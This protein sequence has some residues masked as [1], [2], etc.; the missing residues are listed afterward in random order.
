MAAA[1]VQKRHALRCDNDA[2]QRCYW[3]AGVVYMTT[4]TLPIT[5]SAANATYKYDKELNGGTTAMYLVAAVCMRAHLPSV[6]IQVVDRIFPTLHR[7]CPGAGCTWQEGATSAAS[8]CSAS[9][10]LHMY[11]LMRVCMYILA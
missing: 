7:K 6:Y 3:Q 1:A 9:S 8:E 5:S 2:E 11:V 10:T 4:P